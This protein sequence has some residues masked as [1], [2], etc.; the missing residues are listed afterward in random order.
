MIFITFNFWDIG[1]MRPYQTCQFLFF[2]SEPN[3]LICLYIIDMSPRFF[4]PFSTSTNHSL[5]ALVAANI[6]WHQ[7]VTKLYLVA[8]KFRVCKK[9]KK[10]PMW[11]DEENKRVNN[12]SHSFIT[13]WIK[14]LYN[15]FPRSY[16][17]FFHLCD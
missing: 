5:Q 17:Y 9:M 11:E 3:F 16:F 12:K 15:K 2:W 13:K 8:R 1:F 10:N 7:H 6:L 4:L 14:H